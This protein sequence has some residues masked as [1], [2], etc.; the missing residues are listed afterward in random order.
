MANA[1]VPVG[2]VGGYVNQWSVGGGVRCVN[3]NR[4]AGG[5][6]WYIGAARSYI[7]IGI[8]SKYPRS[9]SARL[10]VIVRTRCSA[11]CAALAS[12]GVPAMPIGGL[13]LPSL[14]LV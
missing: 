12:T 13:G 14:T 8:G 6:I 10:A 9:L 2:L 3:F 7:C 5:A 11:A 1:P 4:T